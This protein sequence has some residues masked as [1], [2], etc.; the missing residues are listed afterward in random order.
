[1]LLVSLFFCCAFFLSIEHGQENWS[2]RTCGWKMASAL[3]VRIFFASSVFAL[4]LVQHT[5]V[6][7]A[8]RGQLPRHDGYSHLPWGLGVYEVDSDLAYHF[9]CES[10]FFFL[11][12]LMLFSY[13][14]IVQ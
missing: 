12:P 10:K 6:S 5:H 8:Y 4:D 3:M 7:V 13:P 9:A 2:G 1:M 11:S 14:Q